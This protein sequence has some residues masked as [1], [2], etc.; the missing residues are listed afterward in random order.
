M[1]GSELESPRYLEDDQLTIRC[2]VTVFKTP[3]VATRNLLNKIEVPPS[4][5]TEN[6]GRLLEGEEDTDVAFCVGGETLV[7]H[8]LVLAMRSPVFKAELYGPMLEG[9]S[10]VVT[11]QDMHPAVFSALLCFIYTD[12]LPDMDDNK[13]GS[14]GNIEM[15]RHLIVAADR[16]SVDRLKLMCE[17]ILSERLDVETVVTTWA[18]AD[19]HNCSRLK[20]ACLEFLTTSDVMD[21]VKA[22]PGYKNLKKTCPSALVDVYEKGMAKLKQLISRSK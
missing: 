6:L 2:V 22:T 15:I 9:R 3:H 10:H 11:I 21:A 8:R 19:Q 18:L 13:E 17:S 1:T 12:S 16:Y 4:D 14:D 7:A 5:I 20:D